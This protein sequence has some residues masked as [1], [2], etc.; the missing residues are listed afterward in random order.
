M[1]KLLPL[2]CLLLF[3]ACATIFSKSSDEIQ[4][5]SEPQGAKVYLDGAIL[6]ETPLKHNLERD[7]F[8]NPILMFKKDGYE[9]RQYRVEKTLNKTALWNFGFITTTF[10]ATSWGIDALSGKMI[11]YSPKAY[12]A[13]LEP[14]KRSKDQGH[15]APGGGRVFQY[16]I[17][18]FEKL[19]GD[20]ARGGGE[21]LRHYWKLRVG[22]AP[23]T[24]LAR[25]LALRR[26]VLAAQA[27]GLALYRTLQ[28]I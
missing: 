25:R 4:I 26:E 3:P 7:T 19:R 5:D 2:L 16:V 27:D 1:K 9:T 17:E 13:E 18:N 20:I 10:G 23:D 21:H 24:A 11:E 12:V 22:G 28:S 6:G 8:G 15:L 14:K